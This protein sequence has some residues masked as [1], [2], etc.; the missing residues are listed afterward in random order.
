METCEQY[1]MN[2]SAMIDGELRGEILT[3]T[4]K[5]LAQCRSCMA[6]FEA[7]Q[8]LD[9]KINVEVAPES[10][11]VR[12]W[13]KISAEASSQKK[14]I[15]IN[16]RSSVV[17]AISIAAVLVITFILGYQSSNTVIPAIEANDPI[18][19][20]SNRGGMSE[21]Q[22]LSLTRQLLTADPVYHKRMFMLLHTITADA[23]EGSVE[24][25]DDL[26]PEKSERHDLLEQ[27]DFE[28][29]RETF[30]F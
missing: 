3:T 16:L 13:D 29:E 17:R 11:P 8:T 7:F 4:I 2:A 1:Q 27:V 6:E 12:I 5:H 21:A 20:A 18:V 26:E 14:A 30:K 9:E 10:V 24:P 15:S 25:L 22:F 19:L 28:E 23:W